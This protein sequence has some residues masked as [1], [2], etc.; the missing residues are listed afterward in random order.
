MATA[1]KIQSGATNV[2][3]CALLALASVACSSSRERESPSSAAAPADAGSDASNANDAGGGPLP[4]PT[5]TAAFDQ[6][7]SDTQGF[8]THAGAPG[9]SIAVVLHGKIAF[10]AGL[11]TRNVAK[12]TPVTTST[13]FRVGSMSKMIVAATAMTLVEQG[14]LDLNAPITKYIP[15]FKLANGYDASQLTTSLLL[16]HSSGFPCDTV[17]ICQL[18][19][20]AGNGP[21]QGFFVANPQPLWDPPGAVFDY[22]NAGFAL[23]AS[24]IEGAAGATDGAYETLA[25]DRVFVPANMTTATFDG[26]AAVA[27][28]HAT[29]YLLDANGKI[30]GTSEPTDGCPMQNPPGGVEAT[31]TDYGHFAEM[32]MANGGTTLQPSSVAAME[33]PH[34]N[35]HGIATAAYGYGLGYQLSPYPDHASITHD[36]AV[37]G[38]TSSLWMVPDL[39]FAVVALVNASG[40]WGSEAVPDQIVQ[41]ALFLFIAEQTTTPT[42][43]TAPST[44]SQYV[45]TYDD[46]LATLGAGVSVSVLTDAGTPALIV[47]AP[48]NGFGPISGP[49]TQL[50]ID[51]WLMPDGTAAGFFPGVDGGVRYFVTRRGIAMRQ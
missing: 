4:S 18:Q 41:D 16:S 14:K 27:A 17:A 36:G 47:D 24:V 3:L 35:T 39:G 43:T 10:T 29:G 5:E 22:S 15:W 13:L 6:L 1:S 23:A 26:K 34:A 12:K 9:A 8:L 37:G 20:V 48:N 42:Y 7:M 49:M 38:Y 40:T 33:S 45:G 50:A 21:R 19:P 31:A 51:T 30:T 28:D 2:R 25:H 44:W 46:G 32:M 11:G